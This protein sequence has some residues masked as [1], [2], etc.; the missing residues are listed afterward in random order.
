M[1]KGSLLAGVAAPGRAVEAQDR[2]LTNARFPRRQDLRHPLRHLHPPPRHLLPA[3]LLAYGL[4]CPQIGSSHL[5]TM[6]V[7]EIRPC[8]WSSGKRFGRE[9][10]V[11]SCLGRLHRDH[12]MPTRR[13]RC[14]RTLRPQTF[15][16]R[17]GQQTLH[18]TRGYGTLLHQFRESGVVRCLD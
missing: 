5:P 14:P 12:A 16:G 9:D 7:H 3:R 13:V 8:A 11:Q 6:T 2:D 4:G 18:A 15:S 10:Q 17:R 1:Q